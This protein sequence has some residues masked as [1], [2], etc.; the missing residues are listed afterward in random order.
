VHPNQQST[1]RDQRPLAKSNHLA[2]RSPVIQ[3][4][5]S[6]SLTPQT[7]G[8]ANPKS[9][10]RKTNRQTKAEVV[11]VY[12]EDCKQAIAAFTAEVEELEQATK[13]PSNE[14]T[15]R[16]LSAHAHAEKMLNRA[17][18]SPLKIWGS[19]LR[20]SLCNPLAIDQ[21]IQKAIHR[22]HFWWLR[23]TFEQTLNQ[24]EKRLGRQIKQIEW[25]LPADPQQNKK[26]LQLLSIAE[27]TPWYDRF[28]WI[29]QSV[30]FVALTGALCL[31]LLIAMRF[32]SNGIDDQIWIVVLTGVFSAL[33][34]QGVMT[35]A[36]H[37][38]IQRILCRLGIPKHFWDESL[39]LFSVLLSGLL[40]IVWCNLSGIANLYVDWG[41]ADNQAN[42]PSRAIARYERAL[43]LD[44]DHAIAHF[45]LGDIY[46]K[47]QR[48]KEAR[49]QYELATHNNLD[50]SRALESYNRLINIEIDIDR[51]IKTEVAIESKKIEIESK[52]LSQAQIWLE[53]C[54]QRFSTDLAFKHRCDLDAIA[55]AYLKAKQYEDAV[56]LLLANS[57]DNSIDVLYFV[58]YLWSN[59]YQ[60]V[61]NQFNP[62]VKNL[63]QINDGFPSQRPS[64]FRQYPPQQ[65]YKFL[66]SL[67]KAYLGQKKEFAAALAVPHL[68]DATELS[69]Q[70]SYFA[71][72][73]PAAYCLLAQALEQ[74]GITSIDVKEIKKIRKE[75]QTAWETC[76][77]NLSRGSADPEEN[78]WIQMAHNYL[79]KQEQQ[80]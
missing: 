60:K 67:G 63:T 31:L 20:R 53:R 17:C 77:A 79:E 61:Q 23:W 15:R 40:L 57:Q 47:Q 10:A 2:D 45:K 25:T 52:N 8:R 80:Q 71:T 51:L 21:A 64:Q 24:Q 38:K 1:L 19:M 48:L 26:W 33:L 16:V 58:L 11:R 70:H 75:I 44:S 59:L 43:K 65:Q 30:S 27:E 76:K 54:Q 4:P 62:S 73:P 34:G 69:K 32:V 18:S 50:S 28:D 39:C 9:E 74:R 12:R 35:E 72:T 78:L 14:L 13:F 68:K 55:Q 36:G 49:L 3:Q 7:I 37:E 41:D 5:A 42:R 66:T 22:S 56:R 29:W 46:E 6:S